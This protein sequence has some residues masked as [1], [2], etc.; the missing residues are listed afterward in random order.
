MLHT[1]EKKTKARIQ[2]KEMVTLMILSHWV[3]KSSN[4]YCKTNANHTE[5]LTDMQRIFFHGL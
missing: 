3:L 2:N 1:I 5:E 4:I